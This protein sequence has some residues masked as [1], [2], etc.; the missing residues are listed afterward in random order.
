MPRKSWNRTKYGNHRT[1]IDGVAFDSKGEAAHWQ[2]LKLRERAGE[3]S[4]LKRQTP[5]RLEV[6]GQL[7]CRMIPDF[8]YVEG[9]RLVVAD[10]KS[11]ATMTPEFKIKCKLLKA[12]LGIDVLVVGRP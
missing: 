3:I 9:G 2:V 6:N 11:P 7:I 1:E 10:F 12:T 5:F 8:S 4:E